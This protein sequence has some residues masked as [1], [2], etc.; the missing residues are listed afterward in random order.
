MEKCCQW[1]VPRWKKRKAEKP[2][3]SV[4]SMS[5]C[6]PRLGADLIFGEGR[7]LATEF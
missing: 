3:E 4:T 6:L 2:T 1:T 7:L 5:D